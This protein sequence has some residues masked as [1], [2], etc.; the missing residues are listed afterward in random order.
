MI[1]DFKDS[2]KEAVN[3]RKYLSRYLSFWPF[4]VISVLIFLT[5]AFFYIRYTNPTYETYT[6]IKILDDAMD[7]DMA[8]PTAMTIFN[9]STV[10]L[11]NERET[12]LST[13][14]ISGVVK[15]LSSNI[16]FFHIGTIRTTEK[17]KSEFLD[18]NYIL[19][20][21]IPNDE[22]SGSSDYV[23]SFNNKGIK[24]SI[25]H[26]GNLIKDYSISGY[27]I[28]KKKFNDI[29]FSF[30][31]KSNFS[32]ELFDE[33]YQI[34]ISSISL[35]TKKYLNSIKVDAL[36]KDSDLLRLSTQSTNS[37]IAEEFLNALVFDYDYDGIKDRQ[38]VFKRTI[39][40]VDSRFDMLGSEL[41]DIEQKKVDYQVDNNFV[42]IEFN[43]KISSEQL[44]SYDSEIFKIETQISLVNLLDESL[45][46]ENY[47]L[48]PYNIGISDS[49]MN[50]LISEYNENIIQRNKF[51]AA[52][53][54][55]NIE[56]QYFNNNIKRLFENI[57][58]SSS[59]YLDELNSML[60]NLNDK[61]KEITGL[62]KDIPLNERELRSIER[63][64]EI[65]EALFL[66]LFQ[67]R[68]EAAINYAVTKPTTKIIEYA[69]TGIN[70][71][72]PNILL[73]YGFSIIVGFLIPISFL[74]VKFNLDTKFHT[75]DELE[76]LAPS[77]PI[78]GEVPYVKDKK[79]LNSLVKFNT[80][81]QLIEGFRIMISNISYILFSDQQ[82]KSDNKNSKVIL[83]TSSIKSEGKT[84]IS[85]N[86]SKTLSSK[87]NVV[88]IGADLRNPQI[89]KIIG[90]DKS[91]KGLSDLIYSNSKNYDD[92]LFDFSEKNSDFK[93]K[94][95]FSGNI[96]PNPTEMLSS[97]SFKELISYLKTKFD[98]I[99]ID[100]A[101]CLVVSDTYEIAPIVDGTVYVTRANYTDSLVMNFIN[102][103]NDSKKLPK[104]SLVL[105]AV[106]NSASYGYK[107]GYQYGY[108]YGYNYSYNYGYGYGYGTDK[109]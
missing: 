93:F 97:N 6:K 74:F 103:L 44:I 16:R 100:S 35:S 28:D 47:E 52:S 99:I 69:I 107:Y 98:Y 89:H 108:K 95:L 10:N 39:D 104:I 60:I 49:E 46:A 67:K 90:I 45:S 72:S 75:R 37:I 83:V 59:N 21:I 9:R 109:D 94:I 70:P 32:H 30:E 102:E 33:E 85:T 58:V 57:K 101:P 71:V 81:D 61:Q 42:N 40:F 3:L 11:E 82:N 25:Y 34:S 7:S 14:I 66:L 8:L 53:S 80:R 79:I 56:V 91:T 1:E 29:P 92:F 43:S 17:H 50:R 27:K 65:K 84:F 36:G 18:G 41:S 31:L 20:D 88:L 77:V 15:K 55:K 22:I 23:F 62:S 105:N 5:A 106:G 24:L 68:E 19:S 78:L 2:N 63:E 73:V 26:N 48:L 87:G 38:L 54:T 13:R 76:N 86:L 12:I 51:I 4:Y 64:L 96:P